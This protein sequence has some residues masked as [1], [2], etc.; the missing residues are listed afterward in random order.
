LLKGTPIRVVA[1]HHD[2]S[3]AMIEW[4]YARYIGNH[5]DHLV[6]G[7]LLDADIPALNAAIIP[8][9]EPS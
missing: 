5:A 9:R 7:A 4:T 3:V 1:V 8:L 6:R 2:T